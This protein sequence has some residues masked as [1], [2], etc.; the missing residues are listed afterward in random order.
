[1]ANLEHEAILRQGVEAWNQWRKDNPD[2]RPNLHMADFTGADLRG[3][4]FYCVDFGRANL[5]KAHLMGCIFAVSNLF[6]V[7][8]RWSNLTEANLSKADLSLASMNDCVLSGVN[9]YG[10]VFYLTGL[11]NA[12]LGQSSL[13]HATFD[14]TILDGTD[15]NQTTCEYNVFSNIDLSTAKGLETVRHTAP[16]SIGIDTL[17]KSKGKIPDVFLRGCGVPEKLIAALPS[18]LE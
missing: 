1:M 11:R 14:Q 8:F 7:D 9:V 15:F 18:L 2:I 17:L 12:N 13:K 6:A 5:S 4:N 3:A 16:S 10:T